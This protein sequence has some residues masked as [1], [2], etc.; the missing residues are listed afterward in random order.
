MANEKIIAV[1]TEHPDYRS[2]VERWIKVE[3]TLRGQDTIKKK[4]TTYLPRTGGMIK[5]DKSGEQ[6]EAYKTRARFYDLTAQARSAL[7]GLVFEKPPEGNPDAPF[8]LDGVTDVEFSLRA[9]REISA[10]G[11]FIAVVDIYEGV[12]ARVT[13]YIAESMINWDTNEAGEL[14]LAVFKEVSEVIAE[15]G[16]TR[17]ERIEYRVYRLVGKTVEICLYDEKGNPLELEGQDSDYTVRVQRD[18]LDIVVFGSLDNLPDCDPLPLEPIADCALAAYQLSADY[19]HA[20]FMAAQ[21]TPWVKGVTSKQWELM[22][23]QGI[24]SSSLWWL[25][26]EGEPAF[27]ETTGAGIDALKQAILDELKQAETHASRITQTEKKGVEA[28]VSLMLRAN[29]QQAT[30]HSMLFS[31]EQG[32]NKLNE[33]L[34]EREQVRIKREPFVIHAEFTPAQATA[35]ILAA[36][37]NGVSQLTTPQSVLFSTLR[38]LKLTEKTD[39]ELRAELDSEGGIGLPYVKK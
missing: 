24:G 4:G 28:A 21:P 35:Q 34:T 26:D 16:F 31:L 2:N 32:I 15:D 20:L 18:K 37:S 5:N 13:Y 25:G 10:K 1:A 19:R 30:I 29:A 33:I 36:V 7:M 38:N 12:M 23:E 17:K 27:L 3:D 9:L 8:G 14:T 6:Y 22:I 39:E 11:R